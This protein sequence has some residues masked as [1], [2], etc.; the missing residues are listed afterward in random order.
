M[1][2]ITWIDRV[3][4]ANLKPQKISAGTCARWRSGFRGTGFRTASRE[5]AGAAV[6]RS[7]LRRIERHCR[8]LTTL[9]A[10]N[11]NLDALPDSRRLRRRNCCQA[12]VLRLFAGLATLG[13]VLQTFI[14]KEDLLPCSPDK[15]VSAVQTLDL[16][17]LKL[18][19]GLTLT[20][21]TI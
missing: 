20:T 3:A 4:I 15:V 1:C 6:N 10:L 9:R 14:M 13:L 8:L 2:L 7:A 12:L 18:A 17:V 16:T 11:G 5:E 21:S 19:L